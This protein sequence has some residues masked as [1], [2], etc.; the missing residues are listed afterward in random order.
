MKTDMKK[1]DPTLMR[2][3]DD[4]VLDIT[5][6]NFAKHYFPDKSIGWFYQKLRG[7]DGNGGVGDFTDSEKDHLRNSLFDF[8]ER[9]RNAAHAI[10]I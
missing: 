10:E 4:V 3:L 8:S 9:V 5:W 1:K 7:V 2:T 6:G